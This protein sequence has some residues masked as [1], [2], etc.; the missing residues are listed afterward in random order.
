MSSQDIEK[1]FAEYL[2]K[3][4]TQKQPAKGQ[5]IIDRNVDS[6][7]NQTSKNLNKNVKAETLE[8]EGKFLTTDEN[9][10]LELKTDSEIAGSLQKGIQIHFQVSH[11]YI[12]GLLAISAILLNFAVYGLIFSLLDFF[13]IFMDLI[14]VLL[15][16]RNIPQ[17]RFE[18]REFLNSNLLRSL[19][20]IF[21]VWNNYRFH[22]K[23]LAKIFK[24]LEIK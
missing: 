20:L 7:D 9:R 14:Q 22:V 11:F 5:K 4:E 21:L 8:D 18:Y 19:V 2:A 12:F 16:N 6:K 17:P 1:Q 24:S 13:G 15:A 3:E 23:Y 10:N